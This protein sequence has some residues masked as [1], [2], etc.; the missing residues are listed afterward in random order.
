MPGLHIMML[1]Y[2]LFEDFTLIYNLNK[3]FDQNNASFA[4]E[5]LKSQGKVDEE[6][7]KIFHANVEKI[8]KEPI[9]EPPVPSLIIYNDNIEMTVANSIYQHQNKKVQSSDGT[10]TAEGSRYAC[11][12]WKNAKCLNLRDSS[13]HEQVL[14]NSKTIQTIFNFIQSNN[15]K[16]ENKAALFLI[17]GFVG[18]PL[19]G[20]VTDPNKPTMCPSNLKNVLFYSPA[21]NSFNQ[22]VDSYSQYW[23]SDEC[24]A[25]MTR[26]ELSNDESHVT[27]AP[28][29]HAKSS[30]FGDYDHIM[31]FTSIIERAFMEGYTHYKD[32][33][34]VGYNFMLHPLMSNEIYE[35]LKINIEKYFMKTSKKSVLIGHNQGTSFVEIFI[36]DYVTPNRAKKIYK[37]SN[38]SCSC[39][40]WLGNLSKKFIR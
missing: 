35:E 30:K 27:F 22:F 9:P 24:R 31:S 36:K 11:G 32:L 10:F 3:D 6:S 12:H 14:T 15:K 40:Y 7:E 16:I 17:S 21:F 34:G 26:V 28:G 19:Y 23:I 5:F 18:S 1:N 20:T 39:F 8:M 25:M 33:F 29:I 37:R 38:I 2:V 4:F 13:N